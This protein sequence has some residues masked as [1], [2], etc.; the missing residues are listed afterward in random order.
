MRPARN[1]CSTNLLPHVIKYFTCRKR[2]KARR[3]N[4]DVLS[5]INIPTGKLGTFYLKNRV[6]PASFVTWLN[7]RGKRSEI[8]H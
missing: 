8:T 1:R 4:M 2:I 3:L 7:P 6:T 5:L